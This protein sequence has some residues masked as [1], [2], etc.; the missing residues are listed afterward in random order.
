MVKKH[1]KPLNNF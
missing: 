1:F